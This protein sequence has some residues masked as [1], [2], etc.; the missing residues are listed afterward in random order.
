MSLVWYS[1][2]FISVFVSSERLPS[3]IVHLSAYLR[4]L[5]N[6]FGL[7]SACIQFDLH[8]F[9]FT[10]RN[11]YTPFAIHILDDNRGLR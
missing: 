10:K 3:C 9:S 2:C 6:S 5:S 7:Y 8:I 1:L 11:R 4:A